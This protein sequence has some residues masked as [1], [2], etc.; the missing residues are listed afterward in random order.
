MPR[1]SKCA[2][3]G[4]YADAAAHLSLARELMAASPLPLVAA[5]DDYLTSH[6]RY[7]QAQQELHSASLYFAAAYAEQQACLATLQHLAASQTALAGSVPALALE[8]GRP[9]PSAEATPADT[10]PAPSL[11]ITCFGRFTVR[12]SGELLK[13][14]PNRNGQAI[15]RYLATRPHYRAMIDAILDVFWPDDP[16]A[17]ARH[18]LHVAVSALR[19][20]LSAGDASPK[21]SGYIMCEHEVYQL[22][23]ADAISTDVAAFM[24]N[25][26]AGQSAAGDAALRHY[27]AACA[28]YTG[29]FLVEDRYADWSHIQREQLAQMY[30]AM[31]RALGTNALEDRRFD[32]A[33]KWLAILLQENHNDD[34]W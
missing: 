5:V 15:L 18:K 34:H 14:C 3:K 21:G 24:A 32:E 22:Q 19:Q 7:Q 13:L 2:L 28:L 10:A 33:I 16:P 25:Y 17:V 4:H 8:V 9:H 1:L 20:S 6:A 23:P 26:R 11:T 31:C 12:R 27:K 30:L 29:E